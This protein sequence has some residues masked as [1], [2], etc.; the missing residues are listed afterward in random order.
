MS[1]KYRFESNAMM[2][3]CTMTA[4]DGGECFVFCSVPGGTPQFQLNRKSMMASTVVNAPQCDNLK[5]FKAFVLERFA[6]EAGES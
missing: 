3:A 5:Q 2:V 1:T 6:D 4:D